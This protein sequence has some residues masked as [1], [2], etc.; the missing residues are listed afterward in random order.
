MASS[1]ERASR[2]YTLKS[3]LGKSPLCELACVGNTECSSIKCDKNFLSLTWI[4]AVPTYCLHGVTSKLPMEGHQSLGTGQLNLNF[5]RLS[6]ALGA[7][8]CLGYGTQLIIPTA[9]EYLTLVPGRHV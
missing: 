5:T 4:H 9:H 6:K 3:T 8:L 7:V 2:A 1:H